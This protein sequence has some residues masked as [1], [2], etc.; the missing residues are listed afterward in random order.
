MKLFKWVKEIR[1]KEG[2]L[3]FKRFAI[4]ETKYFAIYI[5]RIYEHDRDPHLHNHPWSFFGIILKGS[6]IEEYR[7]LHKVV[8]GPLDVGF[9]TENAYRAKNVCS[10]GVGT[11]EYF[12]RIHKIVNGPVT[13]L[14]FTFGKHKPWYYSLPN[15]RVVESEEYRKLKHE[16]KLIK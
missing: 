3:H 15:F 2:R 10:I 14:F 12:H 4:I 1:S 6:Y 13:T 8:F 7:K 9:V 16:G 5:H 11:R